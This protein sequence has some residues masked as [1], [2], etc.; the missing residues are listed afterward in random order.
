MQC[1]HFICYIHFG[2]APCVNI[3]TL[4]FTGHQH[5][6]STPPGVFELTLVSVSWLNTKDT[7]D[8]NGEAK[9]KG[10]K[11]WWEGGKRP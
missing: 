4:S 8:I 7:Q 5:R 1:F 9:E 3:V 2:R 10:A 6:L 11:L